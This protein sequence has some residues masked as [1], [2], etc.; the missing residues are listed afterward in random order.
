MKVFIDGRM[1]YMSGI[2]RYIRNIIKGTMA[3]DDSL[4]YLIAGDL[5]EIS[6]YQKEEIQPEKRTA[7]KSTPYNKT[8]YSAGEQLA[9]SRL[10]RE[11]NSYDIMFFPHYNTPYYLSSN[12]V[13]TVHDLIHF[14]F[15]YSFNRTKVLFARQVLKN[16]VNKT[17]KIIA[18]SESTKNDLLEM[19]PRLAEDKIKVIYQGVSSK[20]RAA[21]DEEMKAYKKKRGLSNYLLFVGNRKPHKNLSRLIEAYAGLIEEMPGLQLVIAG[22]RFAP[23]D[24]VDLLKK[25]YQLANLLEFSDL[26]D[27]ELPYLYSGAEALVFPSLYEGFGLPVLEAMSCNTPVI[28][29]GTS[30]LPEVAGA[31]GVYFN[32]YDIEEIGTQIYNV[33]KDASLKENL[34]QRG[35]EQARKFTWAKTSGNTLKVFKQAAADAGRGR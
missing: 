25:K 18:V 20:F 24:E 22:Q 26:T 19:F 11:N 13:V 31:A 14:K 3:A 1:L 6:K 23:T 21:T 12:S 29:S 10:V 32:P 4:E 28:L 35:I 2:G 27:A 15:A 17:G 9:G 34:K 30:S 16:A 7:I 5:N 8:I 33:L